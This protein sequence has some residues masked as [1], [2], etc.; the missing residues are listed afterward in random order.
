MSTLSVPDYAPYYC[1]ENI[2]QLARAG[3]FERGQADV[4]FISNAQRSCPLWSQRACKKHGEP[5][6]WDYHVV[7]VQHDPV[8]KVIDL[9]STLGSSLD[10]E[11]WWG[12]TFP[13]M[14]FIIPEFRPRFRLIDAEL[15]AR[16][17]ASDRSHMRSEDGSW[18]AAPPHWPCPSPGEAGVD[19]QIFIDTSDASGAPGEV[20][21]DVDFVS[22]LTHA[23]RF[24]KSI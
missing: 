11:T 24:K 22:Y 2:W 5:V 10:P 6:F 18:K 19:L 12:A 7:L 14:D 3:R 17:F 23:R 1:E 16:T 13:L 4:V 20:L 8:R 9:D 15:F 21:D